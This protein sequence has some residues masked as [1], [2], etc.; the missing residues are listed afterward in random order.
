MCSCLCT[1]Q[2][3]DRKLTEQSVSL[4]I[5]FFFAII[6]VVYAFTYEFLFFF[7][8]NSLFVLLQRFSILFIFR[9]KKK[10]TETRTIR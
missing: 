10:K 8:Y 2:G 4:S 3:S 1:F 5:V 7:I 6:F 9:L